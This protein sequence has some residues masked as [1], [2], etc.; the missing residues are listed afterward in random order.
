MSDDFGLWDVFLSMFW[1]MLLICWIWMLIAILSDIFRDHELSGWGK[2]LW[3]FFLI[4]IPW[5]GALVYLI[6]RGGS[7]NQRNLDAAKAT[8]A[9]VR[10]YVRETAG[11][12]SA[13][14]E[15]AKLAQLRENGTTTAEDYEQATARVLA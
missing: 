14:D 5:L 13:A 1:F 3:T 8:E 7:M 15:I 10:A 9:Q 12:T 2:A 11:T 4:I 6:A